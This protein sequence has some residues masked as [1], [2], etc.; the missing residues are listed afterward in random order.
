[1]GLLEQRLGRQSRLAE[2]AIA[3][4]VQSAE[5]AAVARG[6]RDVGDA[7]ILE[8]ITGEVEPLQPHPKQVLPATAARGL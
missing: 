5:A 7:A 2:V 1:M 4:Q 8:A 6:G 3:A